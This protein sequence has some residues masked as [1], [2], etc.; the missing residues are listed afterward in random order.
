MVQ[1]ILFLCHIFQRLY[2]LLCKLT[3]MLGMPALI[4][5]IR[6]SQLRS[7]R[8]SRANVRPSPLDI[9][10][11]GQFLSSCVLYD[12]PNP[13]I[14]IDRRYI[15]IEQAGCIPSISL[16]LFP[17]ISILVWPALFG[18]ASLAYLGIFFSSK[19]SRRETSN[20]QLGLII[21]LVLSQ[22]RGQRAP[23]APPEM[24]ALSHSLRT[25]ASLFVGV[26]CTSSAS[27]LLLV[28]IVNNPNISVNSLHHDFQTVD[29]LPTN[30]WSHNPK[31]RAAV[32]LRWLWLSSSFALM[33]GLFPK[34]RANR[35][36]AWFVSVKMY[37]RTRLATRLFL[38]RGP[39]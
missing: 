9:I 15:F 4:I 23:S 18:V 27:L 30:Q 8:I 2:Q 31:L 17:L 32:E 35:L 7:P 10:V 26:V 16:S 36:L 21:H 37:F 5:V 12:H 38:S 39:H 6:E 34:E 13:L 20:D 11:Q 1:P 24:V 29:V 22:G 25:L 3:L 19:S 28:W 33:I 14:S